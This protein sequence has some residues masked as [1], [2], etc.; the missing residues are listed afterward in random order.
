MTI[1][2]HVLCKQYPRTEKIYWSSQTFYGFF[3]E[4][5]WYC[6]HYPC[7]G[8]HLLW[9]RFQVRLMRGS[10]FKCKLHS[11]LFYDIPPHEPPLHASSSPIPRIRIW[12]IANSARARARACARVV[13]TSS[14]FRCT[15]SARVVFTGSFSFALL[16]FRR[17]RCFCNHFRHVFYLQSYWETLTQM[18]DNTSQLAG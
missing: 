9:T 15:C 7:T 2:R 10:L 8:K 14:T 11:S 16:T 13:F 17:F 1:N 5:Y 18:L 3:W 12:P 6:S 4:P